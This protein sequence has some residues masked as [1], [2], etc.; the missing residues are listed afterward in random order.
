MN[1]S[2]EK[3]FI[4]ADSA[5]PAIKQGADFA[6][7]AFNDTE[8]QILSAYESLTIPED[9]KM[10]YD[11]G[12][13]N[14]KLYF[15]KFESEMTNQIGQEPASPDYDKGTEEPKLDLPPEPEADIDPEKDERIK[16][17]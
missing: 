1:T 11:Y 6:E 10:F 3:E 14:L 12:L 5:D 7:K 13:T 8:K 9:A 4:R 2:S 17:Q 15:D 16:L